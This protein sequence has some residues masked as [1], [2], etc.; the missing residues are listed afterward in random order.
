MS[1][2]SGGSLNG[3]GIRIFRRPSIPDMLCAKPH[4]V[5][6]PASHPRRAGSILPRS[7]RLLL[8]VHLGRPCVL[9]SLA[10]EGP[11]SREAEL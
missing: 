6:F 3:V 7:G 4:R 5:P 8:D 11:V 2:T 9:R 10:C 1:L